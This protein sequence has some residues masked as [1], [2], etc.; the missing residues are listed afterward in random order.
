MDGGDDRLRAAFQ[1]R[2]EL[3]KGRALR[4]LAEL[5]NIGAG[6]EGTAGT[7][8]DD[9]LHGGVG[10]GLR[11]AVANPVAHIGGKRVDRRIID[12][13]E[14]DI[15]LARQIGYGIDRGHGANSSRCGYAFGQALNKLKCKIHNG[16]G[17]GNARVAIRLER[18]SRRRHRFIARD[19]PRHCR[20]HGRAWREG[21]R[22]LAQPSGLRRSGRRDQCQIRRRARAGACRQY[23]G[24]GAL[25]TPRRR[26]HRRIRPD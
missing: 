6:D 14:R 3:G 25:K 12:S 15:A 1:G 11:D 24:E 19:R 26:N 2:L 17:G 10:G 16:R 21:S 18:Q 13:H 22:V 20:T 23:L 8:D 5:G 4:R 9:G 7:D